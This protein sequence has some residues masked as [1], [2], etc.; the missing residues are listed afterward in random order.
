MNKY[1][2]ASQCYKNII[3][4]WELFQ[5]G[6]NKDRAHGQIVNNAIR[7][8]Q[9]A[10]E[11]P[12]AALDK[13]VDDPAPESTQVENKAEDKEVIKVENK[14]ANKE[15]KPA[16]VKFKPDEKSYNNWSKNYKK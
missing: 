9:L 2:E 8:A 15:V 14:E 6:H 11:D 1:Q 16:E 12:F 13:G 5:S 4:N 7:L 10:I 3:R